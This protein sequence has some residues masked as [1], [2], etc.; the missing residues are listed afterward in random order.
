LLEIW[1]LWLQV[2]TVIALI[3]CPGTLEEVT[4]SIP[5]TEVVQQ[6][7]LFNSNPSSINKQHLLCVAPPSHI[8]TILH[9]GK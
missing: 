8:I 3:H 7:P 4:P 1:H 9:Q 2:C 5:S 6:M